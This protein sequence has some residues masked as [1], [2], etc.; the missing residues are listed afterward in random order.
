MVYQNQK[1]RC[2]INLT[3][4]DRQKVYLMLHFFLPKDRPFIK[5]VKP[6]T[7]ISE[8]KDVLKE[9]RGKTQADVC[10]IVSRNGIPIA[11]E[12]VDGRHID[13]FATLSATILG[14]SEV[15]YSRMGKEKPHRVVAE[16]SGGTFLG[17]PL[18]QKTLL[19]VM[20]K[21]PLDILLSEVNKA[22]ET[23]KVVL[24]HGS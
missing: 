1:K 20:G 23:I 7:T 8:L 4:S 6:M 16:S 9:L 17:M 14:A 18:G 5:G 12:G 10:A 15:I 3:V 24:A 2:A 11:Y 13:T 19:V 21:T 22:V